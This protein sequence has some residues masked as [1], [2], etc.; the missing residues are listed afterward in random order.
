MTALDEVRAFAETVATAAAR[1]LPEPAPWRPGKPEDDR[2]P[3]LSAALEQAGW[4]AIGTD[5]ALLQFAG[6]ASVELGRRLAPLCEIDSLLGGSPLLGDLVRYH[7]GRAMRIDPGGLTLMRITR[8]QPLPY[9]DAIGVH[10]VL[11]AAAERGL[12]AAEAEVRAAAWV[13]ASVGYCAGVGQRA[14]ELTLEYAQG[15]RAFG[16]TLSAL[17]PVQQML[18]EV[19][20]IVRGLSLLAMNRP[21][22]EALAHAGPAL[23]Q[24]TA[25]CQQVVG[26]IGFTLEFPLQ[27]A[28]RRARSIELW[29]DA[30][31]AA[32][33]DR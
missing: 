17:A 5:P 27:R 13:A 14:L 11:E 4:P 26:A 7:D 29:A 23:C 10:R 3:K 15:R 30:V 22:R 21:G 32:L 28:Y 24:A 31:I 16:S 19:A 12:S 9:G 6:P 8:A 25:S 20:T 18:A 2:C 33:D 1:T